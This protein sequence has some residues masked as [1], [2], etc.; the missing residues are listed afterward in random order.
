MRTIYFGPPGTGKTSRLIGHVADAIK[1]GVHP[2]R[3]AFVAFSRKAAAE[4]RSRAVQELGLDEEDLRHWSTLHSSAARQ[5][6]VGSGDLV[7]KENWSELGDMLSLK[8][9]DLDEAGRAPTFARER[10]HQVQGLYTLARSLKMGFNETWQR[11]GAHQFPE[12]EFMQFCRVYEAY[13]ERYSLHDYADLIDRARGPLPVDLAILDEAQDLTPAQW[14][15]AD[16]A[17]SGAGERYVA[18]DDD[19]AIYSWAGADI[20]R[21]LDLPGNRIVLDQSHRLPQSIYKLAD[22]ISS[23]ISRRYPKEW[24]PRADM[25]AVHAVPSSRH[26]PVGDPGSWL[27]LARTRVLADRWEQQCRREGIRYLR[28]G[29]DSAKPSEVGAMRAWETVRRGGTVIGGMLQGA[30]DLSPWDLSLEPDRGYTRGDFR[31]MPIWRDGLVGIP[32]ARRRYY[33]ACLRKNR[34]SLTEDPRVTISTIHGVKGGEADNVAMM[35]DISPRVA[36]GMRNDPD[37]EHRVWYVG[38]T[39]ARERLYLVNPQDLLGY[40]I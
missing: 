16:Q 9:T 12:A 21:F 19:Q 24:S 7:T 13:R 22:R 18:G 29:R 14:D 27:L 34:R 36:E 33:E 28:D 17:L 39:R 31:D 26:V 8:F 40:R 5:L 23:R 3:V 20:N 10:G 38:V 6:G 32:P 37:P 11:Y 30:I 2:S 25:G 4:A 15:Y 35:M 1:R